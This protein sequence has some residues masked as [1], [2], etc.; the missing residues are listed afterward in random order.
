[1]TRQEASKILA[2][3]AVEDLHRLISEAAERVANGQPNIDGNDIEAL[4]RQLNIYRQ[5]AK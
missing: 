2:D 4:H 5:Y 1:M 3:A